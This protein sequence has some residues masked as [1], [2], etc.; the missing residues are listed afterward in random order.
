MDAGFEKM[1]PLGHPYIDTYKDIEKKDDRFLGANRVIVV[2]SLDCENGAPKETNCQDTGAKHGD[3]YTPDFL[4]LL[5]KVTDEVFYIPGI[6]RGSVTSVWT[7][8]TRFFT[9]EEDGVSSH[10]VIPATF[11]IA[12]T[13]DEASIKVKMDISHQSHFQMEMRS[14]YFNMT[15]HCDVKKTWIVDYRSQVMR[16]NSKHYSEE[17]LALSPDSHLKN[18]WANKNGDLLQFLECRL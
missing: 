1:L 7:P 12:P 6:A 4:A 8:N 16:L 9:I 13:D 17:Y 11:R 10:D 14:S 2:V 15:Q 3:I 5:K 18:Y